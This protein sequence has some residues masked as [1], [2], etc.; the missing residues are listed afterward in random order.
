MN[1]DAA[2]S[3]ASCGAL[4]RHAGDPPPDVADQRTEPMSPLPADAAA[5]EPSRNGDP[6]PANA[7]ASSHEAPPAL[8]LSPPERHEPRP[9][10][11]NPYAELATLAEPATPRGA[12][13]AEA[14]DQVRMRRPVP[15]ERIPDWVLPPPLETV[16]RAPPPEAP[17]AGR[18]TAL[19]VPLLVVWLAVFYALPGWTIWSTSPQLQ[20]AAKA[21][22]LPDYFGTLRSCTETAVAQ[23]QP[24]TV[25]SDPTVKARY[26]DA[27]DALRTERRRVE[28]FFGIVFAAVAV[29]FFVLLAAAGI[30]LWWWFGVL[31]FPVAVAVE[32]W[33]LWRL[34]AHPIRYWQ[35]PR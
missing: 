34:S 31:V 15:A 23:G 26:D 12:A 18:R 28:A 33:G 29:A 9:T 17:R 4:L 19:F 6:G 27:V 22:S 35:N 24:A 30:S 7:P 10:K 2:L 25:C 13:A 14:A 3:C 32:V 21:G 5:S 20:A 1:D 11:P 16:R 8:R